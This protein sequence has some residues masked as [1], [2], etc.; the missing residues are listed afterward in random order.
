M[1]DHFHNHTPFNNRW[2]IVTFSLLAATLAMEGKYV[3]GLIALSEATSVLIDSDELSVV[4]RIAACISCAL[5]G[6]YIGALGYA[7][8][9]KGNENI[10]QALLAMHY[11][12]IGFD[13][14]YEKGLSR[15]ANGLVAFNFALQV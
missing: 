7:V 4:A 14:K 12:L 3:G 8:S 13:A 11:G 10:A 15:L 6:R 9:L 1:F 5:E 2:Y